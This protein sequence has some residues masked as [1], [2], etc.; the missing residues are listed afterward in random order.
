ME[1]SELLQ[2]F[3]YARGS[4]PKAAVAEAIE[5]REEITPHLLRI[6]ERIVEGPNR[7]IPADAFDHI[8]AMYLLAKFRERRAYPL[9]LKMLAEFDD[10]LGDLIGDV[11]TQDLGSILASVCDDGI[12]PLQ[13][14]IENAETDE[15][16]RAAALQ[17][18][19]TLVAAGRRSRDEMIGYFAALFQ[20]LEREP[21]YIW[22][23][24][25][26]ACTDIYPAELMPEI[27]RAFDERLIDSMSIGP[28]DVTDALARGKEE[29][30]REL[31]TRCTLIDDVEREMSWMAA[32]Q[33][34]APVEVAPPD[35]ALDEDEWID[36]YRRPGPKIGRNDPCPCG[37]GK[38]FK[39]CCGNEAVATA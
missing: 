34:E 29:V 2:Q 28:D 27:R 16:V 12:A 36:T 22:S 1:L 3:A 20:R 21:T 32:F 13:A 26:N 24:L 38:K 6:L 17:A 5:R 30:L 33:P 7:E 11:L 19:L 4:F 35:F 25:A 8:F 39:K 14:L 15:W 9:L 10:R 31:Q 37:S 23:A 18:L